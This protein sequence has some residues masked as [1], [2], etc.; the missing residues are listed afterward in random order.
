MTITTMKYFV[1]NI[2]LIYLINAINQLLTQIKNQTF[3]FFFKFHN[4]LLIL[5]INFLLCLVV[6]SVGI[7]FTL[8]SKICVIR[9]VFDFI[10]YI[11]HFS[12]QEMRA[13]LQ[14]R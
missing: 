2:N 6:F 10:N 3:A 8:F 4:F 14:E 5:K 7:I 13:Q 1:N 11:Y 12:V 9:Q